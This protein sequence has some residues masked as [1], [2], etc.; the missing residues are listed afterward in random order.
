MT[1][2]DF[3][4]YLSTAPS[5]DLRSM[6]GLE[7]LAEFRLLVL[8]E[9]LRRERMKCMSICREVEASVAD[10]KLGPYAGAHRCRTLIEQ[11][12]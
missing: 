3:I 11:M 7:E 12:K 9:L 6:I 10:G 4:R 2:D 1:R 5:D 8:D